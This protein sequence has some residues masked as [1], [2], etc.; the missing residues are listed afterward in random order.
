[1]IEL[2]VEHAIRGQGRSLL[3]VLNEGGR[4]R[5]RGRPTRSMQ[6][7]KIL[8]ISDWTGLM[9]RRIYEIRQE[10][11]TSKAP[12]PCFNPP[13][14]RPQPVLYLFWVCIWEHD[15]NT[16][17][18]V[19]RVYSVRTDAYITPQITSFNPQFRAHLRRPTRPGD[20]G[21]PI[22]KHRSS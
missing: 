12:Q 13:S 18:C 11:S 8:L 17:P 3:L 20:S 14:T 1:M 10:P 7:R 4:G 2:L 5:Y 21:V 15:S 6:P 16:S 22:F 19:D 9:I